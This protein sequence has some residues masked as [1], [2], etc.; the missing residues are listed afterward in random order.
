MGDAGSLALGSAIVALT[1]ELHLIWLLPVLGIVFVV[2]AASVVVNVTAIRRFGTRVLRASPIH[3]H[4][5]EL[6]LREQ[7]LV[8]AF[9]G[10]AAVGTAITVLFARVAGSAS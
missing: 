8:A 3:H 6:G 7:R 5:E 4:F 1:T 10:A 9:A 2:E